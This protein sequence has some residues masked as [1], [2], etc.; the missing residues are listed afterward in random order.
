MTGIDNVVARLTPKKRALLTARLNGNVA[1]AGVHSFNSKRLVAYIVSDREAEDAKLKAYDSSWSIDRISRWQEVYDELYRQSSP[2]Q[3]A[4]FNVIGWNSTYS[5]QP[6]SLE[7]MREQVDHTAA[8]ILRF[9]PRRVL[10][11]GCGTGLI[12]FRVAPSCETYMGTDFS[13][14]AL[15]YIRGLTARLPLPQVQLM[16]RMADDFS[17]LD[18]GTFDTVILNSVIQYFPNAE[19]LFRVLEGAIRVVSPGGRIFLGDVRS[20]AL[21]DVFHASVALFQ[22]APSDWTRDVRSRV[23]ARLSREEELVI[24]PRFFPALR[25]SLPQ[26]QRVEIQVKGGWV[27]NELTTFRYDAVLQVGGEPAP[28]LPDSIWREWQQVASVDGLRQLLSQGDPK[29]QA[30]RSV[31]SARLQ[32]ETEAADRLKSP[33]APETVGELRAALGSLEE[34]GIAPQALWDLARELPYDVTVGWSDSIRKDCYDALFR[35]RDGERPAEV[36]DFGAGAEVSLKSWKHYTNNPLQARFS[37]ER[38]PELRRA[39]LE[40]LPEYMVPSAFVLLD[41]FPLTPSGKVDRPALPAP[42]QARA[43]LDAAYVAPRTPAEE[44]LAAIWCDVLELKQV[45]VHDNFFTDLGGHSLLAT[46][47][48]SRVRDVFGT[49]LPL[50]R[51]FDTPTIAELAIAIEALLIESFEA[52]TD[53]ETERLIRGEL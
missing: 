12:L 39:L 1:R 34:R 10:E 41:A 24:A 29:V 32:L 36:C 37:Q 35:R 31:P 8:R 3:E 11:I 25:Q 19:Y 28:T 6:I 53:E 43:E 23:S 51:L 9:R 47:L 21:L 16:E 50:R 45:G 15:D 40:R 14:R 44:S 18:S 42:G 4:T 7:D 17:A 38:V 46:Q 13:F 52:L 33:S 5:G 26:V 27:R 49:E 2:G 22:A 48:V 30:V 20:L